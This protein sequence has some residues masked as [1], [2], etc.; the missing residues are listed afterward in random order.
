M[1]L[2]TKGSSAMLEGGFKQLV[3]DMTW[4]TA[5]DFDLAA[6]IE[7]KDGTQDMCYFGKLGDLNAF[8]HMKLSGDAGVG[9]SVD[10]EGNK[11][12]L[13]IAKMADEVEAVHLVCWDYGM[14]QSGN[15]ARFK[16]GNLHVKI[17]DDKNVEHDVTY[18]SGEMGNVAVIATISRGI[19]DTLNLTNSAA[20]G[21]LK[22]LQNAKQILDIVKG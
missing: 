21:T 16:D 5:A 17:R 11:E 7:K 13:V 6:L 20:C 8:P 18:D 15:A 12:T 9:D 4:S 22:G 3:C 19:G 1:D 10:G 2:N 14:V